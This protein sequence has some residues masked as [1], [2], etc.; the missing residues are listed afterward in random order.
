MVS[1]DTGISGCCWLTASKVGLDSLQSM[2]ICQFLHCL[3]PEYYY[4][5]FYATLSLFASATELGYSG[6]LILRRFQDIPP[7]VS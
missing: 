2:F 3:I 7:L 6:G 5:F 1:I 4:T